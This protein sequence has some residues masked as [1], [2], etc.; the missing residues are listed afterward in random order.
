MLLLILKYKLLIIGGYFFLFN[1]LLKVVYNTFISINLA[2][3]Y[4]T[5]T[6]NAPG[7]SII[8]YLNLENENKVIINIINYV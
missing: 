1:N 7:I 5:N 3:K 6:G 8:A 4:Y 2:L